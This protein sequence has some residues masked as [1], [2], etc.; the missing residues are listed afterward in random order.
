MQAEV[1]VPAASKSATTN[2]RV[3]AAPPRKLDQKLTTFAKECLDKRV[4]PQLG[5]IASARL[6]KTLFR[7]RR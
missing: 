3:S 5:A 4:S 1:L 7:A 2:S 6:V